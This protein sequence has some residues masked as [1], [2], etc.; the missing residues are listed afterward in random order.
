MSGVGAK[1]LLRIL[2]NVSGGRPLWLARHDQSLWI[3]SSTWA[4]RPNTTARAALD[5]LLDASNLPFEAMRFTVDICL[6]QRAGGIPELAAIIPLTAPSWGR[7][8]EHPFD[9][10]TAWSLAVAGEQYAMWR[11][12]DGSWVALDATTATML[13]ALA[14]PT[15]WLQDTPQGIV[16]GADEY[17]RPC[18]SLMPLEAAQERAVL[19]DPDMPMP[20][21]ELGAL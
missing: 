5:G 12:D 2:R 13:Q 3:A 21:F 16:L 1:G 4:L 6:T 19:R 17:G 11:R 8:S 14:S 18:A 20:L 10:E 7:V 9:A 15:A